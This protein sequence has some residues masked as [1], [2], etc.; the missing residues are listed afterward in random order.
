MISNLSLIKAV[1]HMGL[2]AVEREIKAGLWLSSCALRELLGR[3]TSARH[4]MFSFSLASTSPFPT[5][6]G[7][8]ELASA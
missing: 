1:N 5:L 7:V 4:G 2:C 6:D 3:K 8:G